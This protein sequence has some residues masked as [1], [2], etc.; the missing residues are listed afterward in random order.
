ML[1]GWRC[2]IEHHLRLGGTRPLSTRH[3]GTS[4]GGEKTRA[5]FSPERSCLTEALPLSVR[6]DAKRPGN[7]AGDHKV[8]EC[9][10]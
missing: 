9:L 6:T 1:N 8:P 5:P 2:C 10:T 3:R 7:S 4:P